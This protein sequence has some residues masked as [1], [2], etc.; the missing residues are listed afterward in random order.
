[1]IQVRHANYGVLFAAMIKGSGSLLTDYD[2]EG[3]YLPFLTTEEILKQ[4]LKFGFYIK[5]DVK[6]N[7]PSSVFSFLARI[8]DIGYDKIT[9][10]GVAKRNREGSRICE[11]T[12]LVFKACPENSDILKYGAVISK[13]T[14][15]AKLEANIAMNVTHEEDMVWDWL[16]YTANISDILDENTDPNDE[17]ET[18]E[19]IQVKQTFYI[20]LPN[21]GFESYVTPTREDDTDQPPLDNVDSYTDYPSDNY[22]DPD[23][24]VDESGLYVGPRD[25]SGF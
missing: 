6:S 20:P 11:E 22:M 24:Y 8:D 23:N 18:Q 4:L 17:F 13:S 21:E 12:V 10:V 7:L 9:R 1:M 25:N 16:N 19:N 14:L 5:Y 2:E 3:N 15:D